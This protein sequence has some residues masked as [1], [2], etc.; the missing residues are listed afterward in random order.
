MDEDL[1]QARYLYLLGAYQNCINNLKE[2]SVENESQKLALIYRCYLA[3]KKFKLVLSELQ[4][5]SAS[6]SS[7]ELKAITS[8]AKLLG[9]PN[10]ESKST[11][12]KILEELSESSKSSE[13]SITT[14]LVAEYYMSQGMIEQAL[15]ATFPRCSSC[16]EW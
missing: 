3:Q 13:E 1:Q 11:E 15:K 8:I 12:L 4:N 14:A 9:A 7:N 2:L 5:M 16:L 6:G 10:S